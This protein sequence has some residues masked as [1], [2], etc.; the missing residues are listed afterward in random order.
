M[1]GPGSPVS[2]CSSRGPA[3][4]RRPRRTSGG[5]EPRYCPNSAERAGVPRK[6]C[7]PGTNCTSRVRS[8]KRTV[9]CSAV[10]QFRRLVQ[11]LTA[12]RGEAVQRLVDRGVEREHGH[13]V[14]VLEG[15]PNTEVPL[16]RTAY[17][18]TR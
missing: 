3:T 2:P 15:Q 8:G 1:S 16:Q 17:R 13:P 11:Q 10:A 9:E 7:R 18:V 14:A 6:A 5:S 12:D 4:W